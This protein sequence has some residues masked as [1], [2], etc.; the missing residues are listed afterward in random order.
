MS[1]NKEHRPTGAAAPL[2]AVPLCCLLLLI[3]L[4]YYEYLWI[5][6]IYSLYIPY[7]Y[8]LTIFH[9]FSFVCFVIYSPNRFKSNFLIRGVVESSLKFFWSLQKWSWDRNKIGFG[10]VLTECWKVL[11]LK[12][13][14]I[15]IISTM[16][17]LV[18]YYFSI[19]SNMQN[20]IWRFNSF[21]ACFE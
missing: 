19:L 10:M 14:R 4:L 12:T 17:E 15:H 3:Y 18:T 5:F 7:I 16:V 6:L 20:K 13:K 11:F 1:R 9:I 2:G 21:E 8:V